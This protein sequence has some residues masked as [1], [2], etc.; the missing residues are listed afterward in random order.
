[1]KEKTMVTGV[2][3]EPRRVSQTSCLFPVVVEPAKFTKSGHVATRKMGAKP[4]DWK[5]IISGLPQ[6]LRL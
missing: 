2:G 6:T 4:F 3:V 1:M 5:R